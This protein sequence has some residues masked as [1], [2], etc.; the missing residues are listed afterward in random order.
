MTMSYF[1]VPS[2]DD[3]LPENWE[4]IF[5]LSIHSAQRHVWPRSYTA[6]ISIYCSL[7]PFLQAGKLKIRKHM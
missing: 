2:P 4:S 3:G 1:L 5:D 6:L 7:S